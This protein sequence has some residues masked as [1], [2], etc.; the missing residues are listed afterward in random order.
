MQ[1]GDDQ[2]RKPGQLSK[3]ETATAKTGVALR[4]GSKGFDPYQ[5]ALSAQPPRRKK[6]LRKV[7]EWL[8]AKRRAEELKR[9]EAAADTSPDGKPDSR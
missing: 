6:D 8:E 1:R 7:G 9:Q 4:E 2:G 5:G 3:R